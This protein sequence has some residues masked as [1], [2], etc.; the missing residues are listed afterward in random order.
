M[1]RKRLAKILLSAAIVA[2]GF[3]GL[4]SARIEA[5]PAVQILLDGYPL[6]AS[7]EPTVIKGT[8]LVPFRSISEALGIPVTWNA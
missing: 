8:T 3:W 2:S 6:N 7:A 4:Q 1:N 5:A